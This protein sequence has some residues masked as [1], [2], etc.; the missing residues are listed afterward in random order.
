MLPSLFNAWSFYHEKM[1]LDNIH[2]PQTVLTCSQCITMLLSP[3][4][5][6]WLRV[7]HGGLHGAG[8]SSSLPVPLSGFSNSVTVA[9]EMDLK[10]SVT[11][12]AFEEG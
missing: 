7:W 6:I 12:D 11:L 4:S 2:I 9:L 3:V 8:G 10:Y 5:I 1:L